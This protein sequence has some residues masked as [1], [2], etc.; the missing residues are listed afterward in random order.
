MMILERYVGG[1]V[2][3]GAL[4]A[5]FV[6]T[7]VSTFFS[8]MGQLTDLGKDYGLAQASYYMLLTLPRRAYEMVPTAALLG[9]L[10]SLGQLAAASELVVMRAS[11]VSVAR[12]AAAVL[13]AGVVLVIVTV[14]LG[15]W[16]APTSEQRAQTLRAEAR[17]GYIT[18]KGSTGFWARDGDNF[19]NV[20]RVLPDARLQDVFIYEYG[21]DQKLRAALH[22]D[23]ADYRD[24]GWV[25]HDV[26][27]SVI[28]EDKVTTTTQASQRWGTLINP[29][30]LN[31]LSVAPED[32][33]AWSLLSYTHYL[34]RNNLDARRYQL[35]FWV[36]LVTPLTILVMLFVAVPFVFG[37]L[38]SSGSGLRILIGVMVGLGFY[39]LNQLFNHLGLVYGLA[40]LLSAGLP[41]A[42]FIAGG[43]VAYR[44]VR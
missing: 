35:A 1:T 11:G 7:A 23:S 25:L 12:I 27:Q 37:P 22:A 19:V 31:A 9:G 14:I 43:L 10:V 6:L 5:L 15:E 29:E 36:K 41:S 4:L 44:R 13:K 18:L 42:L 24:G 30:L 26:K 39:L 2:I 21:A 38:R 3:K 8:F 32:L 33:S 17:S 28:G 20:R 34:Q 16:L 40:P